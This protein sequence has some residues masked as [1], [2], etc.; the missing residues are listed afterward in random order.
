MPVADPRGWAALHHLRREVLFRPGRLPWIYDPEHP[1]DRK[2]GHT[3]LI[4]WERESALGCARLDRCGSFGIVR[5]VAISETRQRQGLGR[6]LDAMITELARRDGLSHLRVNAAA[7]AEG[8]Y[9]KCGW[10][11][12]DWDLDETRRAPT[13]VVQMIKQI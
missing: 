5:L 1:D 12:R 4:L 13:P 6:V 8:F 10:R 2:P 3:P 11:V 7:E 9:L